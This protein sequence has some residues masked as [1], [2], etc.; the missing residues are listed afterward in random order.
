MRYDFFSPGTALLLV[1]DHFARFFT[2]FSSYRLLCLTLCL[3]QC[4]HTAGNSAGASIAMRCVGSK[5]TAGLESGFLRQLC[6]AFRRDNAVLS[7]V[8]S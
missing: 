7:K 8:S 1:R 5:Q 4:A 2:G 3:K 6:E